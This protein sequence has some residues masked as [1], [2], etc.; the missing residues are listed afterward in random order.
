[1]KKI[2]LFFFLFSSSPAFSQEFLDVIPHYQVK[3]P[4]DFYYK[5]DY[6]VQWWYF[7][8]HLF[9]QAGR[10]FGYELTFFVVNVQ[11]RDYK[12]EFGVNSIFIS[13]FAISDVI[14]NKFYFSDKADAGVYD[15]AGAADDK[16]RVWIS[17]NI[18]EG[19]MKEMHIRAS[20]EE[21]AIDL[22][23]MPTKPIVLN[24]DSGYSR[25]SE[26]SPFVASIY[27][28]YT[29]V[30]TTGNLKIGNKTFK[31]TGKSWFDREISSRELAE[32]QAGW[33]W[34]AIQLDD[35]K[36]MML[37][38][39][40]NKD[41][42]T[43]RYSSGTFI[44]ADGSYRHLSLN[45]FDIKVLSFYKS[46]KTYARYPSKWEIRVPSENIRLIITPLIEDQ[47]FMAY[48][49]TRNYYWEGA[50]NVEGTAKGRA[51]VEMTGY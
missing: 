49:T 1:M 46:R 10:A 33:D 21:K 25:K 42:S 35:E 2:L 40:R 28:S 17:E 34:F 29:N 8:G 15:F 43:D 45:D 7:T 13:H 19:D 4:Q 12:S 44:Y 31:V 23:L 38:L 16:L 51:Y 30:K 50:C 27:F 22:R 20:D 41:G 3:F 37:Y 14:G 6:R 48:G 9:D 39:L 5:E 11:Q 36:E 18:L 24:G 32:N 47:E 26:Q